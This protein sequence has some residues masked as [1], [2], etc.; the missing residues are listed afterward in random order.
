MPDASSASGSRALPSPSTSHRGAS[1][2]AAAG[3]PT[4]ARPVTGTAGATGATGASTTPGGGAANPPGTATVVITYSG[5]DDSAGAAQ[6]A[7]YVEDVDAA[8]RCVLTMTGPSGA[9][10]SAT[11]ER[12]ATPDAKSMQC[13]TLSIPR[14]ALAPGRWSAVVAYQSSGRAGRSEPVTIEVPQ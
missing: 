12:A 10:R 3:S 6:A 4:A 1:A 11:A 8:G 7:A 2:T 9:G 13:G 5:W 14:S